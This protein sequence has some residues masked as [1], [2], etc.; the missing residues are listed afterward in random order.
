MNIQ[1]WV[2]S[3]F[4]IS[5]TLHPCFHLLVR[6]LVDAILLITSL[7]RYQISRTRAITFMLHFIWITK[8]RQICTNNNNFIFSLG[9]STNTNICFQSWYCHVG[10]A[11]NTAINDVVVWALRL[12]LIIYEHG[13]IMI[14]WILMSSW[15]PFCPEQQNGHPDLHARAKVNNVCLDLFMLEYRYQSPEKA[16]ITNLIHVFRQYIACTCDTKLN[17]PPHSRPPST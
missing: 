9:D 4:E 14:H 15:Y 17:H 6:F 11:N 13:S 3:W 16:T 1:I 8:G 10:S 2:H 12:L 5:W 7:T